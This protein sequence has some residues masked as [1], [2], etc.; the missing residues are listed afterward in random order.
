MTGHNI[1]NILCNLYHTKNINYYN[2][3]IK[4]I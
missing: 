2:I 3:N 1:V 4:K